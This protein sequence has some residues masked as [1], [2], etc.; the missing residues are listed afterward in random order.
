MPG[1]MIDH[2]TP[3]SGPESEPETGHDDGWAGESD[4]DVLE[5]EDEA[6]PSPAAAG[7][8]RWAR[9]GRRIVRRP[10]NWLN[11]PWPIER[12]VQYLTAPHRSH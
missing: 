8:D 11:A 1:V 5:D 10:S 12:V 3:E 2:T 7:S 9:V 4:L 6:Q